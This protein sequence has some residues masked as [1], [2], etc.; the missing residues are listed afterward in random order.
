MRAGVPQAL[1]RRLDPEERYG[2]RLTLFALALVLVAVPFSTLLFQVVAKGPLTRV[3]GS[4]ADRLNDF[5]HSSPGLVRLLELVSW[6]GR[7]ASLALLV[8]AAAV[9]AWRRGR[10]RLAVFLVVTAVGAL[11]VNSAVK[12]L[13]DRPRPAVDHPI[14]TAF[15]KSFPSG[16]AMS[17]LVSYGSVLLAFLPAIGRRWR[18]PAILATALLVLFIGCSRVILGVHFLSDVLAGYALGL[19]WLIGAVAAFEIW[20]TEEGGAPSRPLT[21][22]V[23]PEAGEGDPAQPSR[24]S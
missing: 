13:V 2:L 22:G 21:E 15:G 12:I 10:R 17:S 23:E 14:M 9:W 19:A 16:H 11:L 24:A 20:R 1:R 6:L 3:D 8:G 18:T 5:A 7:P 4:L